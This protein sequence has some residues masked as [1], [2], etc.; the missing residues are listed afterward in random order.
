MKAEERRGSERL[1]EKRG[2][3][4][5]QRQHRNTS[6]EDEQQRGSV[7]GEERWLIDRGDK[8]QDECLT[9]TTVIILP[10]RNGL[11]HPGRAVTSPLAVGGCWASVSPRQLTLASCCQ[12]AVSMEMYM[13]G[14]GGEGER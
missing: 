6:N 5:E 10:A 9:L 14:M 7:S 3:R 4:D 11:A 8:A 2:E 12:A 13:V 1:Y